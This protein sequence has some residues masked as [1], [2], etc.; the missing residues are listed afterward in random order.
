MNIKFTTPRHTNLT[1]VRTSDATGTALMGTIQTYH[2]PLM[3]T[4]T[5]STPKHALG[6]SEFML[7][8]FHQLEFTQYYL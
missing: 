8:N 4:N 7:P 1:E 6:S 5:V 3:P 2:P